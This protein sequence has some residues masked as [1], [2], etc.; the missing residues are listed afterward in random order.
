MIHLEFTLV[1]KVWAESPDWFFFFCQMVSYLFNHIL[2][3]LYASLTDFKCYIYHRQN[4]YI[5]IILFFISLFLSVFM[6]STKSFILLKLHNTRNI[7]IDFLYLI[8]FLSSVFF[9]LWKNNM[10]LKFRVWQ[11]K[12]FCWNF[13]WYYI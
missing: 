3:I 4:L 2:Y 6:L 10:F 12:K 1:Y 7:W 9:Y 5:Y 11:D 8:Y 13:Y